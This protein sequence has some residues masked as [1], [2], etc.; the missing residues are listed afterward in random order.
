ML[1]IN[2]SKFLVQET[3]W[4]WDLVAQRSVGGSRKAVATHGHEAPAAKWCTIITELTVGWLLV[5]LLGT[6]QP[7]PR[8]LYSTI[9]A[10]ARINTRCR[11]QKPL[12][13]KGAIN[14]ASR[15]FPWGHGRKG[16]C[17]HSTTAWGLP[18][19]L[20]S[21]HSC[22]Q[23]SAAGSQAK[24]KSQM[25]FCWSSPVEGQ[26]FYTAQGADVCFA[27]GILGMSTMST[28]SKGSFLGVLVDCLQR[29]T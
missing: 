13:Q 25:Y 4:R 24:Q 16:L 14:T 10:A 5:K 23:I 29:T 19:H 7:A 2:N 21:A 8:V 15:P 18:T 6:Q 12:A 28:T 1:I 26:R 17:T 20:S 3:P 11:A 22:Q 27:S 9:R